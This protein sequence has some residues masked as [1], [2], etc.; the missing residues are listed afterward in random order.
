MVVFNDKGD[1]QS[2]YRLGDSSNGDKQWGV[3][4]APGVWHTVIAL[5]D[6]VVCYEVKPGPWEPA[7][8]KE[9]ASWAP[10][11]GA[12]NVHDYMAKIS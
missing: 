7:S 11:E 3:D 9:F 4:V 8:D 5:S 2:R 1:V 10:K 6:R 12:A